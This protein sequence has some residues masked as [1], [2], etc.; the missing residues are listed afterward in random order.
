MYEQVKNK[1]NLSSKLIFIEKI[2]GFMSYM[3]SNLLNVERK[4]IGISEHKK[5]FTENK[6]NVFEKF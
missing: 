6:K 3:I 1:I 5:T 2:F 4:F